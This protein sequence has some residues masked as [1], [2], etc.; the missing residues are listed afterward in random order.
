MSEGKGDTRLVVHIGTGK[1]ATTALQRH[2]FPLLE[3]LKGVSFNEPTSFQHVRRVQEMAQNGT[4]GLT[5]YPEL[6]KELA[7]GI[8]F[9][10]MESLHGFDPDSWEPQ[11]RIIRRVFGSAATILLTVREPLSYLRSVYQ[12][13]VQKGVVITPE[14]FFLSD[15]IYLKTKSQLMS[16]GSFRID[17]FNL[18]NLINTYA[19]AFDALY[20][21]PMECIPRMTYMKKIFGLS[22]SETD[23]LRSA[24]AAA[25]RSNVSYSNLAMQITFKREKVLNLLGLKSLGQDTLVRRGQLHNLLVQSKQEYGISSAADFTFFGDLELRLKLEQLPR[26]AFRRIADN[27]R[28]LMQGPVGKFAGKKYE[29]PPG[30]L[31]DQQFNIEFYQKIRRGAEAEGYCLFGKGSDRYEPSAL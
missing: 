19:E 22:E 8:N 7:P 24:Y 5:Q 23:Q 29:L 2:V 27:W 20:V 12:Q 10:S 3:R 15:E 9:F 26:R 18:P 28:A 17:K 1:T 30:V 13:Y 11:S 14:E 21:V 16:A 31:P 25:P 4:V 6:W